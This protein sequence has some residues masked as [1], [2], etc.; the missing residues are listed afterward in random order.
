MLLLAS[1]MLRR[2]RCAKCGEPLVNEEAILARGRLYHVH[3]LCC[4]YCTTRVCYIDD[5]FVVDGTKL[6]CLRC[7][8]KISPKC[9]KCKHSIVD[10]YA[11]HVLDEEFFEDKD[12]RPLDRDCLWGQ[13]LMDHIVRDVDNIVPSKY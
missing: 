1:S 5:S 11:L 13:V 7:F 10:E 12:G 2:G 4:D 3:H 9:H 6:A 8:D